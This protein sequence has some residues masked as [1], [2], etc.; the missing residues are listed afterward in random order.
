MINAVL[1]EY[2]KHGNSS[3]AG[4]SGERIVL[5]IMITNPSSSF[6]PILG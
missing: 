3:I 2:M 1:N 6:D 4:E 5:I